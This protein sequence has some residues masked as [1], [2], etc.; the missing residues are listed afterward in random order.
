MREGMVVNEMGHNGPQM[1]TV[2]DEIGAAKAGAEHSDFDSY[3]N[4]AGRARKAE[5]AF[6]GR[7]MTYA[8]RINTAFRLQN[9]EIKITL[10]M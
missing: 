5:A 10:S 6:H 9:S 1:R 2:A 8:L 3:A 7:R 4:G